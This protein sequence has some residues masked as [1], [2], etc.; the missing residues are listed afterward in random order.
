M[1]LR[2]DSRVLILAMA[3]AAVVGLPN[4]SEAWWN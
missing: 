4:R 2:L 1:S 3:I